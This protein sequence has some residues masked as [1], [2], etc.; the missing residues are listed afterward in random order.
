MPKLKTASKIVKQTIALLLFSLKQSSEENI[1]ELY[2]A[3]CR[4]FE[5]LNA[6]TAQEQEQYRQIAQPLSV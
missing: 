3:E 1:R 5:N 4:I 2:E 6:M